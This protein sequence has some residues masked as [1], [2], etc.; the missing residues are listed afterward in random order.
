[1]FEHSRPF[2]WPL[3]CCL[4]LF[5]E[6]GR[7]QVCRGGFRLAPSDPW[8]LPHDRRARQTTVEH[9]KNQLYAPPVTLRNRTSGPGELL[10]E[11]REHGLTVAL[12]FRLADARDLKQRLIALRQM[13]RQRAQRGVAEHDVWRHP[14]AGF[15]LRCSCC[16]RG[17]ASARRVPGGGRARRRCHPPR[18]HRR[19]CPPSPRCRR[20]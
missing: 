19:R 15:G 13:G 14:R 20:W 1:M 4:Y 2:A 7:V 6:H 5:A 18:P 11:Q 3:T 9:T 12:E 8:R 10:C 17:S 16:W